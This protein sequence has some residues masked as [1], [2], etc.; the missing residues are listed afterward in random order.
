MSLLYC[1]STKMRIQRNKNSKKCGKQDNN[2]EETNNIIQC[3][4]GANS[5]VKDQEDDDDKSAV[6]MDT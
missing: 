6:P 4:M 3:V 2:N 1:E 5:D